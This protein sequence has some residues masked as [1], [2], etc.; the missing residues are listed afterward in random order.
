MG[1]TSNKHVSDVSQGYDSPQKA[2]NTLNKSQTNFSPMKK[3]TN[4]GDGTPKTPNMSHPLS[5]SKKDKKFS[6]SVKRKTS[7]K[8]FHENPD[9]E[10]ENWVCYLF[11]NFIGIFNKFIDN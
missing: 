7:G 10:N 5:M 3:G 6:R 4:I 1:I 8:V 9:T 11:L 2:A